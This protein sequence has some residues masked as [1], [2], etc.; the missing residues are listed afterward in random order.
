MINELKMEHL[1]CNHFNPYT[2]E[3]LTISELLCEFFTAINNVI[4]EHNEIKDIVEWLKEIGLAEETVKTL[5]KWLADGTLKDI[6]T[7]DV[8]TSIN[9]RINAI[10]TFKFDTT[11]VIYATNLEIREGAPPQGIAMTKDR[12]IFVSQV[13]ILDEDKTSNIESFEI[14]RLTANGELIDKMTLK[15]GGHGT[16]F[17]IEEENGKVYIWNSWFSDYKVGGMPS[18]EVPHKLGRVEYL[19]NVILN[20]DDPRIQFFTPIRKEYFITTTSSNGNKIAMRYGR[21][22]HIHNISDVKNNDFTKGKVVVIPPE[23]YYQQGITL[24]DNFLYWRSGD[25]RDPENTH[26]GSYPDML[27]KMNINTGQLISSKELKYPILNDAYEPEDIFLFEDNGQQTMILTGMTGGRYSRTFP[28]WV[29][30]NNELTSSII[31]QANAPKYKSMTMS[32]TGKVKWYNPAIRKV[33]EIN[34]VG[35]YYI[36]TDLAKRLTDMPYMGVDGAWFLEVSPLGKYDTNCIQRLT[37]CSTGAGGFGTVSRYLEISTGNAT[38]WVGDALHCTLWSGNTATNK[39]GTFTLNDSINNYDY[40]VL[41]YTSGAGGSVEDRILS[42]A[43]IESS[44]II[45]T[46]MNFADSSLNTWIGFKHAIKLNTERTE[47]TV[48]VQNKYIMTSG[49]S[50]TGELNSTNFGLIKITG[51]RG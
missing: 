51:I 37:R 9:D 7:N 21:D 31:G 6:I 25:G 1:N 41:E 29:M 15:H 18:I 10:N 47:F 50:M 38:P 48:S 46:F 28:L 32:P 49:G 39:D 16:S 4:K 13:I 30:G 3:G 35:T 2:F 44:A 23:Y 17:G 43:N 5:S 20:D 26:Y 8:L 24:D 27:I 22:V 14:R 34:T 42:V 40:I 19:P 36:D 11:D 45:H 33:S 12:N